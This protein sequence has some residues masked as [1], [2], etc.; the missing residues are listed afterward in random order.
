MAK[1]TSAGTPATAALASLGVAFTPHSYEHQPGAAGY[2]REAAEALAVDGNRVFK[3]LLADADGMLVVAIVPVNGVLD[4]KALANVI[5]AKRAGMADPALAERK[6]G[7]IV[8]GISPIGQKTRHRTI[9]DESAAR[10]AT[11]F[12]SGGRRGFDL[13]L[14]P[15]DLLAVTGG[16]LALISRR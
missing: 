11:V 13:E 1:K 15:A 9:L 14:D 3:T 4:L 12:V 8:G 2:G 6:T 16:S 7:Y 10:F 5:G